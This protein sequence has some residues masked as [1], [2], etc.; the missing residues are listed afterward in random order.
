M[1]ETADERLLVD[2]DGTLCR[3]M[4]RLCE[5]LELEYGLDVTPAE[6]TDW[7]YQF[8][9]VGL[10]ISE[11]ITELFERRPE[12]FLADLDPVSGSEAALETLS[13]AG[14]EIW[15]VT[16]RPSDTHD[17]TREWL[18]EQGM[19]YDH[20]VS[21]VPESKAEVSGD[22][23]IDDYH[24]NVT[25]AVRAGMT[26]LAFDRPY[27]E[28]IDHDRAYRVQTWEDVLDLLVFDTEVP[29]EAG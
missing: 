14:Y 9:S 4:P 5:Y 21:D 1:S 19:T 16:H 10:G 11:V 13:D 29:G 17:L 7:S 20:Y 15:I 3:N 24:G 6:I 27:T 8:E 25:D 22:V 26:G 2:V 18:A 23:L 28:R 12:W